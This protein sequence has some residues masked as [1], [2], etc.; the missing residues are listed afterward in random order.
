MNN[1]YCKK[2]INSALFVKELMLCRFVIF[3]LSVFRLD[4]HPIFHATFLKIIFDGGLLTHSCHLNCL[5]PTLWLN[6]FVFFKLIEYIDWIKNICKVILL[7]MWS[8]KICNRRIKTIYS[9][10]NLMP[11][12]RAITL[13]IYSIMRLL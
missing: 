8:A 9:Y 7:K 3:N 4:I 10:C 6:L 1:D 13:T 12:T 5:R 11:I 2:N